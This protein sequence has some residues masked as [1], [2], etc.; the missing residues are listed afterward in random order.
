LKLSV[1]KSIIYLLAAKILFSRVAYRYTIKLQM[2]VPIGSHFPL[3][4]GKG[5]DENDYIG[6]INNIILKYNLE[7]SKISIILH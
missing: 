7:S 4:A 1:E 5:G 3:S 6:I 2:E